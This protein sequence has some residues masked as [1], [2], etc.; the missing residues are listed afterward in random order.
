MIKIKKRGSLV[1]FVAIH[2]VIG[3][4][5]KKFIDRKNANHEAEK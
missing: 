2:A 3:Y 1:W 5:V 4:L